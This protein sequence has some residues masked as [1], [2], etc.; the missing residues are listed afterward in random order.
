MK[1]INLSI[2]EP[3]SL[4]VTFRYYQFQP[5]CNNMVW[6]NASL[7]FICII[8]LLCCQKTDNRPS[9]SFEIQKMGLNVELKGVVTDREN[10]VEGAEIHWGDDDISYLAKADL[11]TFIK[12]HQYNLPGT[13]TITIKLLSLTEIIGTDS[14]VVDLNYSE[15]SFANIQ[16]EFLTKKENELTILTINLHTYQET[17]Q[18]QKLYLVADVIGK[19]DVDFVAFQEC[20]QNRNAPISSGALRN[21]NMAIKITEII[22][23][24]YKQK[25]NM[26]WDWAHYGWQIYEEGVCVISKHELLEHEARLVSAAS[27]KNDITSRKVIFGGYR[28][29]NV[30]FNIFSAHLH[31]RV[32]AEDEEQNNQIKAVKK[33]A[34]EKEK[35]NSIAVTMV[36]G[37]FNGNPTSAFPYSEGYNTMVNNGEYIDTFLEKNPDANTTPPNSKYFTVGG[38]LPGRI[39]YI[40]LKKNDRIKVKASQIIFTEN[41]IG[42][43]SDHY[44][45]LTKIEMN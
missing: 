35:S 17:E 6:R 39:D 8:C 18:N 44:G 4:K 13:Y 29:K 27:S 32:S 40:F 45:V 15:T 22:N 28:W 10:Q 23:K 33:M 30:Q 31:W 14:I 25:Y 5:K 19:L 41:V 43:V 34:T 16:N 2:F 7:S 42:T 3:N 1:I 9:I 36:C 26:V 38:S 11:S 21:D 20:A 24:K 12:K 37:D